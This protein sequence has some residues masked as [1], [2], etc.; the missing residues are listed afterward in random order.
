MKDKIQRVIERKV[1]SLL[2]VLFQ[3]DFFSRVTLT[4]AQCTMWLGRG[5][6]Y[7]LHEILDVSNVYFR[8]WLGFQDE[9]ETA[10]GGRFP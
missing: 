6:S 4:L 1:P 3:I 10:E 8:V 2:D 5:T 7:V 9:H